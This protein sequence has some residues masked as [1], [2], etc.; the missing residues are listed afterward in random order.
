MVDLTD[1]AKDEVVN[2]VIDLLKNQTSDAEVSQI[3]NCVEAAL[4]QVNPLVA[5]ITVITNRTLYR[6]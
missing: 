1:E 3:H 4:E 6:C 2:I 5:K